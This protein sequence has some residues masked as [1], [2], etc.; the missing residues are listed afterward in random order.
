MQLLYAKRRWE[1]LHEEKPYHDGTFS[2]WSEKATERTPFH[3]QDG[4]TVWLSQHDLTPDDN[5]L[6]QG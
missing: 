3:F 4:V 2:V 1:E 6:E 5:F